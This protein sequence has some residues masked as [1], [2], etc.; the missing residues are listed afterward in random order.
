MKKFYFLPTA[1]DGNGF[2]LKM[3]MRARMYKPAP[4]ESFGQHCRIPYVFP[5]VKQRPIRRELS[6]RLRL[7]TDT[8]SLNEVPSHP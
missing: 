2:G 7:P 8:E 5:W 4:E 6:P 3:F 1:S